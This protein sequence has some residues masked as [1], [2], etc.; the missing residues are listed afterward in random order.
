M[1]CGPTAVGKT[2]L[3]I[4]MAEH[5]STGIVSADSRQFYREM[6]VGTAKPSAAERASAPHHLIDNL[7]IHDI[8]TAGMFEKDALAAISEIFTTGSHALLTGG[9]GLFIKA[10]C[11]GFDSFKGNEGEPDEA[12]KNKIRAMPLR[13]MQEE[14]ARLDPEYYG[15]VDR[16]NPRRLQRALEVIYATGEKYS[17]Q[18]SGTIAQRRFKIVKTGLE[19]PR[20][21]LH[22]RINLRVDE[23]LKN[24][25]LEEAQQLF[26]FRHLQPLQS[27]G[28]Q[29]IFEY[30]EGKCSLPQAIEKIKLNTRRYAKR[31]MTWFK[32]DKD[33]RWFDAGAGPGPVIE[34]IR[35]MLKT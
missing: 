23:M 12:L 2:A 27:V 17:Q 21:Q 11:E 26:A 13:E 15:Q 16:Q 22:G 1:I 8:Y 5:F 31:Q 7:S 30:L 33:I 29:E 18:R 9:S 34:Y 4:E 3:A 28:Y 20:G 24:G 10:V 25:L 32:K 14:L 6:T 19:L 35:E